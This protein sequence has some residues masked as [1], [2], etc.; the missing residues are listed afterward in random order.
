FGRLAQPA[1]LRRATVLG[2]DGQQPRSV[3]GTPGGEPPR[4][5]RIGRYLFEPDA[6]VLAAQLGAALAAEHKLAAIAPEIAYWT[7]DVPIDDAALS[8]FEVLEVLPYRLKPLRALLRSR[9][10][11]PLEIKKRGVQIDPA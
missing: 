7:A 9:G 11:G 2:N 6:A 5:E 1:G 4:A 8:C 10:I 3:V